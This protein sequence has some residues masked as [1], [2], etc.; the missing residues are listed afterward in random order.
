MQRRDFLKGTAATSLL[1][2]CGGGSSVVKGP[3]P[4]T[5]GVTFSDPKFRELADAALQAAVTASSSSPIMAAI[6]PIP[7]GTAPCISSE[8]RITTR[9]ASAKLI[10]SAATSAEYSPRLWPATR[11]G[12]T[13][14]AACQT[15]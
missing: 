7:A 1:L 13:P 15:R 8:R 6:A 12:V 2:A 3:G 5:S 14:P 11:S 9:I 10:E 4:T